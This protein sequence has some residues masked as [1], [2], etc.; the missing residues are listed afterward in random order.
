MKSY[1]DEAEE[2]WGWSQFFLLSCFIV[3]NLLRVLV[4]SDAVMGEEATPTALQ[5][6]V[7]LPLL[8]ME[9][10]GSHLINL[11]LRK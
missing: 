6:T 10:T 1:L 5:L 3:F 7:V 4:L 8:C 11:A 2:L 9:N